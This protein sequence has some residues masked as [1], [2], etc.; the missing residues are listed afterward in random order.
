MLLNCAKLNL[1]PKTLKF[2][3]MG[4]CDFEYMGIEIHFC[5]NVNLW[6]ILLVKH[7]NQTMPGERA[8]IYVIYAIYDLV[9]ARFCTCVIF[10]RIIIHY[11]HVDCFFY[12]EHTKFYILFSDKKCFQLFCDCILFNSCVII[13]CFWHITGISCR[14]FAA[15]ICRSGQCM[16]TN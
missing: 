2:R 13:I 9:L 10:E 8:R 15:N 14:R 7:V 11:H 1:G 16:F 5:I 12:A 6:M 3:V 4:S